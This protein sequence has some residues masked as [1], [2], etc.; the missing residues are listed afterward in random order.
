TAMMA[1]AIPVCVAVLLAAATLQAWRRAQATDTDRFVA[2]LALLRDSASVRTDVTSPAPLLSEYLSVEIYVAG[3]V[4]DRLH[5]P[6]FAA[7]PGSLRSAAAQVV[8]DYPY[9]G[10]TQYEQARRRVEPA[11]D[12]YL[13]RRRNIVRTADRLGVPAALGV[14]SMIVLGVIALGSVILSI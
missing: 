3:R 5:S 6:N 1:V 8:A 13:S 14:V 11:F 4:G 10:H 12:E 7:V 9:V 2:C